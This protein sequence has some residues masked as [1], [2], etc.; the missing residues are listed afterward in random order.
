MKR[1][2]ISILILVALQPETHAQIGSMGF[3]RNAH[4]MQHH[5][6]N[7]FDV[8]TRFWNENTSL[9]IAADAGQTKVVRVLLSAGARTDATNYFGNTALHDSSAGGHLEVTRMLVEAKVD[10]N[11]KNKLKSTPLHL[12]STGG[13]LEVM[14]YL[15]KNNADVN[16]IDYRGQSVLHRVRNWN[17]H[18]PYKEKVEKL[19]IK[20]GAVDVSPSVKEEWTFEKASRT[21]KGS[22]N[23]RLKQKSTSSKSKIDCKD[24]GTLGDRENYNVKRCRELNDVNIPQ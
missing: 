10:V 19:L 21:L 24:T 23:G 5:I 20:H 3:L 13:H 18:I 12:A 8:E 17:L 7:G 6:D 11:S 14:K 15:I 16:A 2:L 4:E 9:I 1:F 22:K